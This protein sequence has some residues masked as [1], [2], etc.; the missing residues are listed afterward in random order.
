MPFHRISKARAHE[1]VEAIE[2]SGEVPVWLG[3]DPDD[4]ETF[5]L[6]TQ[7]RGDGL[8]RRLRDA[9]DAIWSERRQ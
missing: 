9:R 1:Q 7:H 4:G 8:E 6:L 2:R 5:L 3:D